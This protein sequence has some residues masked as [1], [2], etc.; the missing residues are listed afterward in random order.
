MRLVD[1]N[2]R[3]IGRGGTGVSDAQ[4]NPVPHRPAIGLMFNCPCGCK[5]PCFV[6][7]ANPLDGLPPESGGAPTW[8][9]TGEDFETLTLI[10]SI[11]RS[12]GC[13]KQWHGWI[14]NGEIITC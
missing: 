11:L 7:M 14:T 9:R 12:R 8:T 10:P 1:L 5:I 3:W 2:P 13:E 4:G 6:H